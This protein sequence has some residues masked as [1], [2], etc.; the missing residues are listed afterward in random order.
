MELTTIPI[1]HQLGLVESIVVLSGGAVGSLVKDVIEDNSLELPFIKD[2]KLILGFLGGAVVGAFVGYVIDGSFIT[3]LLAGYT[4]T[5]II[6]GLLHNG[7]IDP[8]SLI[9]E[10]NNQAFADKNKVQEKQPEALESSEV[11]I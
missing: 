1:L 11:V 7:T 9:R 4:G 6:K 3:A 2:G 10:N 8:R 5:S